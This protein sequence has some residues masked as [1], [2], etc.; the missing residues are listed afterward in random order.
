MNAKAPRERRSDFA[1]LL[2]TW[3]GA[4]LSPVAPGTAG[5]LAGL[6]IAIILNR[7]LGAGSLTFW[8]MAAALLFPG[9]WAASVVE[10][11]E[12]TEDPGLVVVDEVIG[13]WIT[14][15]AVPAY[16]WKTW[17][18]AFA[19][20]RIL[21]VLKPPPA[22]QCEQLPRGWGIVADDVMSGLY[23]ALGIFVLGRLHLI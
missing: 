16:N 17:L 12:G 3:F 14:L 5:S 7:T 1:W 15:A 20:F 23:G 19:L 18:L 11:R 2:A 4:G 8:L 10:K 6:V 21:D 22:R 13:Q 9:I